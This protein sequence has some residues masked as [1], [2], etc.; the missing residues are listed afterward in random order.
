[1]KTFWRIVV[2]LSAALVVVGA[3]IALRQTEVLARLLPEPDRARLAAGVER[4]QFASGRFERDERD[5]FVREHDAKRE[6][7]A[8]G[9]IEVVNNLLII[10]VIIALVVGASPIVRRFLRRRSPPRAAAGIVT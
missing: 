4:D 3:L 5:G 1:M 8:R 10:G 9:I 2:I 6:P 7:D